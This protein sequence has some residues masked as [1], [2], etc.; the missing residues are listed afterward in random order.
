M[1]M[2]HIALAV[3]DIEATHRFYTELMGFELVKVEVVP[4]EGGF[5]HHVFYATGP[6]RDQLIAFWDFSRVPGAKDLK[7]NVN[8]DL[9]LEPL[10]NHI[11]FTA[12]DL[13]DIERK[14]QRWLA[15]GKTVLEIDH[16]WI[17]SIYTQDPDGIFVEFAVLTRDFT[18]D[19]ARTAL[20][21]LRATDPPMESE[22]KISL[23]EP[24]TP[25]TA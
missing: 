3:K 21:L 19:D 9:G 12:E 24:P 8:D 17:H 13:A 22:P 23:H 20:E 16:G 11:A 18:P 5:A 10:T 7:T 1:G 2:S 6:K 4:K 25:P 15:G 14:K